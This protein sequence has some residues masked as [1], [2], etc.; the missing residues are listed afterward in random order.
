MR[1]KSLQ[2]AICL[3]IVSVV[4]VLG[5]R[6]DRACA[7]IT[8][9]TELTSMN[10]SGGPFSVPLA[11]DPS[12]MLGDSID[13][14][15]FVESVVTMTLSSQRAVSPGPASVGTAWAYPENPQP[16]QQWD[17]IDP[18]ALDG[19]IFFVD[20][21][22]DVFFD[23]TLTDVDVR[24]GRDYAGMPDG[25]SVALL[26]NGP[27][28]IS[29]AYAAVFDKDAPNFGLFPPAEA[30]PYIGFFGIEIPLG[31]DINGNGE[32][33]KI[34]L[35]LGTMS[36]ANENRQFIELP[37]G[38]IIDQWDMTAVF[39]MA[40]V[41]MSTD[42]PFTIGAM[43]PSTGLP[44]DAF[45]GPTTATSTLVNPVVPPVVPVP[46]SILLLASGL[47]GWLGIRRSTSLRGLE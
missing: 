28:G 2:N 17:P 16:N 32:D 18:A 43:G 38:T 20:S 37:N 41:D 10:L 15:G 35:L 44:S 46:S 29:S 22:F 34:K 36:A 31:A 4:L 5:G 13:G 21:F 25:A 47:M 42:P 26:D 7:N 23:L 3:S 11:S 9:E 24:P 45:G 19:E 12:N 1:R 33:D 27:A 6:A 30:D 40:V 14:Y 39:D 8:F